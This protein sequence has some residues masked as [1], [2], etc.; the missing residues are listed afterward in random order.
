MLTE[1]EVTQFES[2]LLQ[3]APGAM[4]VVDQAGRI[5]QINALAER[6][7]GYPTG[8]L[9]GQ[10]VI[11]LIPARL[12]DSYQHHATEYLCH[13]RPWPMGTGPTIWGRRQDGG[14]FA[15][16]ISLNPL[17]T[18]DGIRVVI[19]VLDVSEYQRVRRALDQAIT[20]LER[21]ADLCDVELLQAS[22]E[23]H[24]QTAERAQVEAALR[25]TE[26]LYRQLVENQPLICQYLP[27][28]TLTFVNAAYA[29][30]FGR[31]PEEVIGKRFIEFLCAEDQAEMWT[32]LAAFTPAAPARQYE[33]QTILAD[34]VA[35]WHLWHDF[36]F[37]D[38]QDKVTGFQ[39]VGV[40][41]TER[42]QTE[43][44]LRSINRA[45][46]LRSACNQALVKATDE[47][48]LPGEICRLIVEIGGYR[49]AW[50]GLAEQD[51]AKT[52]RPV[53]Q[54]GYKAGYLESIRITWADEEHGQ[55]PTGTA[56][57]TQRPVVAKILVTDP[58]YTPWRAEAIKH[59]YASSIALP[60]CR[61]KH[62]LGA[63]NIYAGEADAFYAEEIG[64]LADLAD[65]LAYGLSALWTRIE[66]KRAEEAL[67]TQER[68]FQALIENSTDAIALFDREGTVLYASPATQAVLGYD[69]AEVIDHIAFEFIHPD[70]QDP[71]R[72]RV[73]ESL[74]DP[75]AQ[76]S[77]CVQALHKD[78]SQRY[79]E[80]TLTNL[81]DDPAVGAI[82]VN[83]RDNTERKR[84][85]EALRESESKYRRLHE[86]MRDG[87]VRVDMAGGI[88]EF[89]YVYQMMLGYSEEELRQLTYQDLTLEKWRDFEAGI[90]EKQILTR[91]Y[92][93]IYE[94]EYRRKDGSIFPIDLR[95]ILMRDSTGQPTCMWAIVRDITDRK[96][97]EEALFEEKE[98]AQVT[99][100]SIGDAVI[101]TDGHAIVDYLNP[102]AEALTGWTTAEA[103][104]RYLS[105]VFHIVNEQTRQPAAD[106]VARCLQEGK[107]VGLANHSVLISRHGQEYH[108]D[109]SAAPIRGRE[110]Q[111][112]GV[113]LVFHDV[114]ENRQLTRQL[115]YDAT[116]DTLTGLIN[117]P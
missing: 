111:V 101:T 1:S 9:V 100:H 21:Q 4:L 54:V 71:L 62:V 61:K 98:R 64:L 83:Y 15:A 114:S 52:V 94:K 13:P 107:I 51:E 48:A 10:P 41:I 37:F 95:T 11:S 115:E 42:K 81:L 6:L 8:A 73:A 3:L 88:Q 53:G 19:A 66:R 79:L 20:E 7:L 17:S 65:D 36:A 47:A 25:E 59:G 16:E 60:L 38:E 22:A 104:G 69:P 84:A 29:R 113:V 116:H 117:R 89:N 26:A 2:R 27:D 14:E 18:P 67:R 76:I 12:R 86:S 80:G 92:S 44:R 110:G 96:R 31:P 72:D 55:G 112:L 85:E 68:Q 28:T 24:Q 63:L 35:R 78:G 23:L 57:R 70:W 109:D 108:I 45:L 58:H 102:V 91:G 34:G 97:A 39:S 93:E 103:H 90:V 49:L 82:V 99:L 74:R 5:S 77:A 56:I 105:E 30:F 40:D 87:F 32:Y 106:P 50:V 43:A 33:R 46:Q 75:K